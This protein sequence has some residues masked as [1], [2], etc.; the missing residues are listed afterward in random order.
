MDWPSDG[1]ALHHARANSTVRYHEI[2]GST[3]P[4]IK[5]SCEETAQLGLDY[6]GLG[7]TE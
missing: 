2:G 1:M 6:Q 5:Q 7:H 3:L 4:V